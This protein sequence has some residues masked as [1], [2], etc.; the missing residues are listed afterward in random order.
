MYIEEDGHGSYLRIV[1]GLWALP[2]EHAKLWSIYVR[3][4]R[5][6]PIS[7]RI[8]RRMPG[9]PGN[10]NLAKMMIEEGTAPKEVEDYDATRC[11]TCQLIHPWRRP[12]PKTAES[13]DSTVF[14]MDYTGHGGNTSH[15]RTRSYSSRS[16]TALFTKLVTAPA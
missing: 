1:N 13:S 5:G 9:Y 10:N 16:H 2:E 4:K 12:V 11:R 3:T 7:A 8:W 15:S 6:E 14:Q